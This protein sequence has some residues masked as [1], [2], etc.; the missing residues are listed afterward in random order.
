MDKTHY[1]IPIEL[2]NNISG[3]VKQNTIELL[4]QGYSMDSITVYFEK[5]I[6]VGLYKAEVESAMKEG[7]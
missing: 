2:S 1:D 6:S 3:L 7:D 5:S 4:K